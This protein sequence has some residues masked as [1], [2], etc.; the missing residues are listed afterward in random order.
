MIERENNINIDERMK[1]YGKVSSTWE[2][3]DTKCD[4]S[5]SS[6]LYN[7]EFHIE[8]DECP[9]CKQ[10]ILVENESK[11][12]YPF[13]MNFFDKNRE[14]KWFNSLSPIQQADILAD[15]KKSGGY[16]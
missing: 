12:V 6:F 10:G 5:V 13:K 7:W 1:K 8:S 9:K 2:C 3:S 11:R 15:D 4:Y 16:Y 14:D